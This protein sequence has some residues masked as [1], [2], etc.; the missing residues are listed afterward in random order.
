MRAKLI[1]LAPRQ[2]GATKGWA[3]DARDFM[4]DKTLTKTK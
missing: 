3:E 4:R 1:R 2:G